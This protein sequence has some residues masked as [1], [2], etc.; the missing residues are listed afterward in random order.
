MR[1]VRQL[2]RST[3][4]RNRIESGALQPQLEVFDLRELVETAT[5]RVRLAIGER[6]LAVDLPDNLPLVR[7]D[8]VLLDSVLA[9]LL[10]NAARHT[11]PGTSIAIRALPGDP[12]HIRLRISDSGPGVADAHL[13][14]LFDKFYRVGGPAE[15]ARQGM[16]IGLSVVKGMVEA[17]GGSVTARRAEEGGLAIE[18][19]LPIAPEPPIEAIPP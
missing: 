16:G 2:R 10:E 15:G 12:G 13:P 8:A 9:N 14:R 18:L 3:S 4:R 19:L 11:P 7:V 1:S 17:L 6:P 5:S